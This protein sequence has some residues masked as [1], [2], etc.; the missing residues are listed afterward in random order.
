[1]EKQPK[2]FEVVE[3]PPSDTNE[4]YTPSV[5]IE[6]ARKVLGSIDLDPASCQA[7]NQTVRASKYYT[8]EQDGLAQDWMCTSLWLNPPFGTTRTP[9]GSAAWQ[10][11][12]TAGMWIQRLIAEYKAGTVA[13][14]ILLT[15]ADP[16][17]KWFQPLWEYPIC[18]ARDRV[19]FNRPGR[20]PPTKMQFGTCFVYFG[21]REETFIDVFRQFGRVVRAVDVPLPRSLELWDTDVP[22]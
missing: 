14:A 3:T 11:K 17:Q 19:F 21:S 22:L 12:S 8:V 4:R 10:G 20:L 18:F 13:Q 6:A 2:L 1:M 5:Y 9:Y 16:K 15:K 7:A